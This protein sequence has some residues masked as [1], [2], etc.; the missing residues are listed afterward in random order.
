MARQVLFVQGAGEGTHDNWDSKLV[1]SLDRELGESYAVSYPRMPG[2][3]NPSYVVW[4]ATLMREFGA[5]EDGV[6]LVGHSVGGTILIHVLAEE[7]PEL[8]FGGHLSSP[9]PSSV[10]G[11]GRAMTSPVAKTCRNAFR[12]A[13]LSTSIMAPTTPRCPRAMSVSMRKRSPRPWSERWTAGI[14]NSTMI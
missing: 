5:L 3:D 9:P 10:T 14:T 6:I 1:A 8:R 4:K 11:D 13:F 7:R 12:P 2:E